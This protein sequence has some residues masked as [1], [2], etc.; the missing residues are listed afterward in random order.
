MEEE[1]ELEVLEESEEENNQPERDSGTTEREVAMQQPTS[2]KEA[3]G[4]RMV[5]QQ[6]RGGM[7]RES[8]KRCR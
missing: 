6:E 1:E 7:M 2:L 5:A 8:V 4:K 3:Q